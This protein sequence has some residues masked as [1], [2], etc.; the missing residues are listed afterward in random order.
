MTELKATLQKSYYKKA[1]IYTDGNG[2]IILKSYNTDVAMIDSNGNFKRLWNGWS[3]TT[4]KHVNDFRKQNG[5]TM[6]SK[7]EWCALP[8]LN[9][10][11]TYN[12]H[13]SNGFFEHKS[14]ILLTDNEIDNEIE[15]I[16]KNSN[17]RV[18]AWAE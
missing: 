17:Y 15:R 5:F 2:N 10:K 8:C 1:N 12:I 18:S 3:V 16:E 14:N 7:K 11:Q 13:Y 6:L 9:P 4:A